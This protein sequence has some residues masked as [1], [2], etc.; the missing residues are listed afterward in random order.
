MIANSKLKAVLFSSAALLFTA[1][2]SYAGP[3]WHPVPP[4][5]PGLA[6]S[7][8]VS[9]QEA[10]KSHAASCNAGDQVISG[11]CNFAA[12]NPS[13]S[14]PVGVNSSGD[15]GTGWFCEGSANT[16]VTAWALCCSSNIT[17]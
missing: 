2:L 15:I 4:T 12:G 1:N 16:T 9:T 13:R 8:V 5:P 17:R 11:G 10:V 6:C 14:S 3:G 7:W